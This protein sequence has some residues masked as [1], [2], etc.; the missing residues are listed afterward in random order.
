MHTSPQ[1]VWLAAPAHAYAGGMRHCELRYRACS[2]KAPNA[3]TVQSSCCGAR[4]A[5]AVAEVQ[6]LN[7]S[8]HHVS[9]CGRSRSSLTTAPYTA[10]TDWPGEDSSARQE[11]RTAIA[12]PSS[13]Q[14]AAAA[15]CRTES[16]PRRQIPTAWGNLLTS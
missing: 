6:D 12:R 16:H 11:C 10:G 1:P 13:R 8:R 7:R 14:A 4:L 2:H 15:Q 3:S 9:G 5:A